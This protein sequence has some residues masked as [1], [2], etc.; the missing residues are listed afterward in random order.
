IDGV[1][2]EVG[3]EATLYEPRAE[4]E[5]GLRPAGGTPIF[6]AG[7]KPRFEAVAFNTSDAPRVVALQFTVSDFHDRESQEQRTLPVPAAAVA[8]VPI[9]LDVGR[10]GFYSISLAAEGAAAVSSRPWRAAVIDRYTADDSLFGVNHAPPWPELM[11]VLRG[12]GVTWARDWSLKWET[13]ESEP[14]RFDFGDTDVVIDAMARHGLRV[15]G[16]LPYPSANWSSSAPA[17]V[18][19]RPGP[20]FDRRMVYMPRSLDDLARYVKATVEHYKGRIKAWEILN[21][22]IYCRGGV[23]STEFGYTVEDYVRLLRVAYQT[24]KALDGATVVVGGIGAGP[25]LYTREF[26]EAGG[27]A[28]VDALNLHVYPELA[29]PEIYIAALEELVLRMREG[30]QVRPLW[31]TECG[32]YA[33]DDPPVEPVPASY[34]APVDDEREAAV[35]QARLNLILLGVGA[36]KIFYHY[37]TCGSI[38]NETLYGM[39]FEYDTQPRKT[40]PVQAAMAQLLGPDT[41]PLGRVRTPE[42]AYA[43]AFYSAGQTVM[44]AWA[45]DGGVVLNHL[46]P[47]AR[48]VDILGNEL[49][50]EPRQLDEEPLYVILPGRLALSQLSRLLAAD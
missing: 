35:L 37:G 14:G 21:E 46:P 39:F 15:L 25:E 44:A 20:E 1:Q 13:V 16:L 24:I 5:L 30:G 9:D 42:G 43:W 2:L 6:F 12:T 3:E 27:L 38:N 32:Y 29:A 28:Y 40:L 33:D 11:E 19:P 7:Q 26:I 45:P 31:V 34:P 36:R 48:L 18:Q 49:P 8:A 4:V 17:E 10:Q 47:Q 23:L 50:A 22:P 41:E